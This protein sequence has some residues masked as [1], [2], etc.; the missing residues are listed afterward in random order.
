MYFYKY[1]KPGN[2]E[3]GSLRRGEIFFASAAELN[4]ASECRP[5]F[6][7]RGSTELWIRLSEYILEEVCFR[8]RYHEDKT[9]EEI[10][11]LVSLGSAAGGLVK[12]RLG[13]KDLGLE[14]LCPLFQEI[15]EDLLQGKFPALQ[16]RLILSLSERFMQEMLPSILEEPSYIASFSRNPT[17]PTMWGHYAGAERGFVLVYASEDGCI[18]VHSCCVARPVPQLV[19]G[20]LSSSVRLCRVVP[21]RARPMCGTRER[22]ECGGRGHVGKALS[23]SG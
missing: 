16:C 13:S 2:L 6:V 20:W 17:N 19:A 14:E 5:R 21:F 7:L 15:L 4:D 8:S 22:V 12:S 23:L 11:E 18:G 10:R 1:Q 3:F 9:H